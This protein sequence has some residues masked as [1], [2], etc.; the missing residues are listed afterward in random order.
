MTDPNMLKMLG[1]AVCCTF[2]KIA[3]ISWAPAPFFNEVFFLR[4]LLTDLLH[5]YVEFSVMEFHYF[6]YMRISAS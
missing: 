6:P 5:R 2:K 4:I 1:L 3:V